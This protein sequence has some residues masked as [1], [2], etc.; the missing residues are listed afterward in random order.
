M[1]S[2][3]KFLLLATVATLALGLYGCGGGSSPQM[4]G[5]QPMPEDVDLSHVT[6]GFMAVAGIVQVAAG[7]SID[8]GD[9]EFTCA[10]G[11]A[12]CEV[13]VTVDSN[14]DITATSTGGTVT[15]MNSDAYTARI[16]PMAVDLAPVTAGFMASAGTVQVAAGQSTVHDDIEFSCAAGGADCTVVVEVGA[17]GTVS[18][19]STGGMVTAMNSDAYTARITP[20]A[21]DLAP[22]TAGFMAGAGTVQVPAGQSVEHGDIAFSCAAGGADCEVMVMVDA[23]GDITATS[24][25][26]MVTAMNSDAYTDRMATM[27][28]VVGKW[29]GDWPGGARTVLTITSVSSDGQVTGTYRHQERGGQP[30]VLEISPDGPVTASIQNGVLSFSFGQ[31]T[32]E[33]TETAEDTLS[34]TFQS[35]PDTQMFSVDVDRQDADGTTASDV[36]SPE[37]LANVI[38]LVANDSRQDVLG[39]YVG[40]WFW[41]SQNIGAQQA[42]VTGTYSGGQWVNAIVSHDENGQLQHNVA[43]FQ[44]NPLQEAKPWARPGRYINT[45]DAPEELEGV[46]NSTRSITDHGLGSEWQAT[47]LTADYDNSGSLSI[48]VATDAQ[49]SDG[50]QDPFELATDVEYNIQLPSAPALPADQDFLVVW[51]DD[52]DTIEG[53]LGGSAGTF[54]CDNPNG[55]AFVDNHTSGDYYAA[56]AGITFTPVGGTAQPVTPRT[57]GSVP[58]ADYLAFGHWVYVPEDVTDSVN[59]EFGVYAS[60]GDPFNVS[61]LAALTGTATYL[62][63]A[64]GKYY[65]DGLSSNPTVGSFT[66]DATLRAD[67]GDGSETGFISGEVNNFEFEDDVASSLPA[68]VKLASRTYDYLPEGFGVSPGST[69]IFDSNW[70][71]DSPY[72][73]GQIGGVTEANVDGEDWY[74]QWHGAFYGNGLATTD[75]PPS[76]VEHSSS[77]AGVFGTSQWNNNGRSDRGLTGAFGAHRY[78]DGLERGDASAVA[79]V[80]DLT[81]N[82]DSERGEN[83][84]GIASWWSALSFVG[85]YSTVSLSYRAAAPTHLIVSNDENGDLQLNVA[86][87]EFSEEGPDLDT[88]VDVWYRRYANTY[89]GT[90]DYTD[91]VTQLRT[92]IEDHGLDEGEAGEWT[93]TGLSNDYTDGGTLDVVIATDLRP[94]VTAID[95][96]EIGEGFSHD[97]VLDDLNNIIPPDHDFVTVFLRSSDD[98]LRGSL[99]GQAGEFSCSAEVC[100]LSDDPEEGNYYTSGSGLVFTPDDG[101]GPIDVTPGMWGRAPAADYLAFGYWLY[102]PD[103]TSDDSDYEFG[104]FGSVGDLF[105]TA[106]LR[107]LEGTAT[108]AGDASGMYFVGRHSNNPGA[109][110]FTADVELNADFGTG[111]DTGTIQ[112]RVDNLRFEDDAHSSSFPEMIQLGSAEDW[113]SDRFGIPHR[114]ANIF[115]APWSRS[116]NPGGFAQGWTYANPENSEWYGSWWG[117]F[118]GNG[119]AATDHPTGIA[120]TFG[121]YLAAFDSNG[122]FVPGPADSGLAGGFAARVQDDQ[123]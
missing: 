94:G 115:D 74:G 121:S 37:A 105:D 32:F 122:N 2:K 38:D 58:S 4:G 117:Q 31:S 40:G 8:H 123:Q 120:G 79:R 93:V 103:D 3:K 78:D 82:Y 6:G 13:T 102:V 112:G 83:G 27:H 91:R 101:T 25:G 66:A 34:F 90:R 59:Y 7:Q 43:V 21:V 14:G 92:E 46:T 18:A 109:G 106:N 108:Y 5:G 88:P 45:Y 65:V 118:H 55:C 111:T 76:Y 52:G 75:I 16:T 72:P 51:I 23:N 35:S 11:G 114:S 17:D 22:V 64:V 19:T 63:D 98:P 56:D 71:N 44:Q 89:E 54:S 95:P 12:D 62:G 61:H 107:G 110:S 30:F 33:F 68:T 80:V 86:M 1:T 57:T 28:P 70:R 77:V 10:A 29:A 87:F 113:V 116:W 39:N 20:M 85:D 69:N 9:I 48:Y 104:V 100:H 15:A 119:A 99:D 53:S 50:S 96:F 26:G 49:P 67:F 47:E 36:P 73:G 42:A 24:T 60:G 81:V 97:I 41:R 84:E